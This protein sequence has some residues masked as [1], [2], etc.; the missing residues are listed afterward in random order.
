MRAG[1]REMSEA[2]LVRVRDEA[3]RNELTSEKGA[4]ARP[5]ERRIRRVKALNQMIQLKPY[6]ATPMGMKIQ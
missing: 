2:D 4:A 6:I 3:L 1:V 5:P